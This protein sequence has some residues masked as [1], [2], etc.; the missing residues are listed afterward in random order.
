MSNIH[1]LAL[2]AGVIVEH[3]EGSGTTHWTE[4]NYLE[5]LTAFKELVVEDYANSLASFN[6]KETA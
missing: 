4:G 6:K 1:D 2:K 3:V 5:A